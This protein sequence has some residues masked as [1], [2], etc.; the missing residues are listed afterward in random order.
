SVEDPVSKYIPEFKTM[1]LADGSD[2]RTLT[3]RDLMTHTSGI[4]RPR[5]LSA[6]ASLEEQAKTIASLPLEFA[7]GSR[8]KYGS[9][10][11]VCGRIIEVASGVEYTA[12]LSQNIFSPLK[13]ND[14]TFNPTKEQ[15]ERVVTLYQP[16]DEQNGGLAVASHGITNRDVRPT[17]NPSGGLFST[18]N[19]L[20]RFYQTILSGG[21]MD[22]VRI[23]SAA[24][25]KQMTTLKTGNITTGFTP[26][27]GWGLGWCIVR[28][29]QGVSEV[30]AAGSYGHGG[31]FGTQAW[32]DPTNDAIY[33]LLI[34]RTKF[35]NSDGATLRRDFQQRAYDNWVDPIRAISADQAARILKSKGI[36]I[37]SKHGQITN[38]DANRTKIGDR[39]LALLNKFPEITDLSFEQTSISDDGIRHLKSLTKLEWLNLF[40]TRVG[41]QTLELLSSVK[42][43]KHLPIGETQVTD[44]GMVHLENM[45]QLEYLGIRANNI[46]DEGAKHLARLTNLAGLHL[47]ET[48]VTDKSIQHI[49]KLTQL[50]KLY[51]HDTGITESGL[52]RL[53]AAL[54]NCEIIAGETAP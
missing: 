15:W 49:A 24:A 4:R 10:L 32:V 41:D 7:P 14:T 26:G 47:G 16:G 40:Q 34:Q 37:F 44:A 46:T 39:D 29:P 28:N 12:F 21:E 42:S 23:V 43:L 19:D 6:Q 45:R 25:A 8:W 51:I 38:F 27:N 36:R 48:K 20:F 3:I 2:A 17:P 9:G 54:P 22:G 13:M 30:L 53:Q 5:N 1:K 18:A 35:G 11:S 33:L 52:A 50:K 31:A